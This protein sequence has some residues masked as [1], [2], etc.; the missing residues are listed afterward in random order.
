MPEFSPSTTPSVSAAVTAASTALPPSRK[1]CHARIRR[2]RMN[3]RDHVSR[4]GRVSEASDAAKSTQ[5]RI[6][7]GQ[8]REKSI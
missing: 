5:A 7:T 6:G 3:G 8:R 4:R 1:N 2:D